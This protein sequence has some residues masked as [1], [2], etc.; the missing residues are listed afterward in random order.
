MIDL[1]RSRKGITPLVATV[2]LVAFSIGLGA[3]VMS[4]GEDYIEEKA[5][6]VQGTAEIK[7]ACDM[8]NINVIK[9][10]GQPQACIKDGNIRI[11]I[12]NGPEV[13]LT[14][15]HARIAGTT[16]IGV[17][18]NILFNPLERGNAAQ[19]LIPYEQDKVGEVRQVKLT[20][21]IWT[22][23][24]MALCS[25]AAIKVENFTPCVD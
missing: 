5:E 10:G 18:D 15:I 6:F 19:A 21:K 25:Q 7:S 13:D 4:W 20:P 2:L 14:N 9:I 23:Q 22:G 24:K 16:G 1:F 8:A 3:I 12:D 17:V 11:W